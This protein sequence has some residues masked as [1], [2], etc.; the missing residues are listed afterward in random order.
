MVTQ[1]RYPGYYANYGHDFDSNSAARSE[2]G[3]R[4][5]A[6]A[7]SN[8]E[9]ALLNSIDFESMTRREETRVFHGHLHVPRCKQGKYILRLTSSNSA[10]IFINGGLIYSNKGSHDVDTHDVS[11]H[12]KSSKSYDLEVGTHGTGLPP[13]H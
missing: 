10:H 9:R 7:P 11:V 5:G 8:A 3:Q 13:K 1:M 6:F 2:P 4:I 12:L